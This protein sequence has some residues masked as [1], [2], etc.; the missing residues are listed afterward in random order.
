MT[1]ININFVYFYIGSMSSTSSVNLGHTALICP[2]SDQK[3]NVGASIT[4][5]GGT[6]Y[7]QN[8]IHDYDRVDQPNN[9]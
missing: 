2:N 4:G 9:R 7:A 5:N 8:P 1:Q 3:N 6:L